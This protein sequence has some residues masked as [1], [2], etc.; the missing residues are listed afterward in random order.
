VGRAWE[1]LR[2]WRELGRSFNH[3]HPIFL[4]YDLLAFTVE[5]I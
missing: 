1:V 5:E 2:R 4:D 3:L